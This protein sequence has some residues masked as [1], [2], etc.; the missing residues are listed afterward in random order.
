MR[1]VVALL[2]AAVVLG[3]AGV[4]SAQVRATGTIEGTVL[5]PEGVALPGAQV[6]VTGDSEVAV[7]P[8]VVYTG[9]AGHFRATLLPPG[10]YTVQVSLEGFATAIQERVDVGVRR[11]TTVTV[12]LTLS[13]VEETVTVT[14]AA[15]VVDV[16]TT[17]RSTEVTD[18]VLNTL[19][20]PRGVGGDLMNLSLDASL[21]SGGSL[22][23]NGASFFG[24]T[25]ASNAFQ[26]DGVTVTD[27]SGGSQFPFY[28]PDWFEVID[29]TT[30]GASADQGKA[31]GSI[32]NV[33]TKSGGN[34]YKGEAN[35][36]FQNNSF[37]GYNGANIEST[38]ADFGP[39]NAAK[40]NHRYDFSFNIGG[41]VIR[42]KLW[43]FAGY[44]LFDENFSDTGVVFD[45]TENS[46]RFFGK[47]TW[48]ANNDNRFIVSTMADTYTLGGRPS[49]TY[50]QSFDATAYEPSMNITPNITW[51]TI[52]GPNSFMEV[53]YSGF[54]GYFDLIPVTE[55]PS[56]YD[57]GTGYLS[58]AYWGYYTFDRAR[59]NVQG[60]ISYFAEDF[61]GDHS[62]RVG[63]EWERNLTD[64]NAEYGPNAAGEHYIYYPYFG[65]PYLA[66]QFDP[67]VNRNTSLIYATT[68]YAQDDW[69][70]ANRLT[71]NLGLRFD[72]WSVGY[73]D[74]TAPVEPS[75]NDVSPRL[76]ANLDVFGDGRTS[77]YF[78]WGR[79]YEEVHGAI[80][81]N[82]DP[83]NSQTVAYYWDNQWVE[84]YR[85]GGGG[86]QAISPDL[87]NQW[88]D[89][90][91]IGVD[92]QV[93]DDLSIGARYIHKHDSDIIGGADTGST[94]VPIQLEAVN[95]AL[96]DMWA[97][98]P[99][100]EFVTLVN[101]PNQQFTASDEL[102]RDYNGFQIKVIKR[103]ADNWTVQS[104]FIVQK[105]E[106]NVTNTGTGVNGS[107]SAWKTP[108]SFV[109][110]PGEL[111]NSR[112]YVFKLNASYLFADPIG[113]LVGARWD[114]SSGNPITEY[115]RFSSDDT[116]GLSSGDRTVAI[117][118]YGSN[119]LETIR[120]LDLRLEK[121]FPLGGPY[122]DIG[123][124]FDVF[125]VLNEDTVISVFNR[126]PFY[127]QPTDIVN[128]RTM[129]LGF[130]WLF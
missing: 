119:R 61:A 15:P 19:P 108:N 70:I 96:I 72:H 57:L 123:V 118:Q 129:R 109:N 5:D 66:Y 127:N 68:L 22:Q 29:Q 76:G 12:T 48:Q 94:F 100:D 116:G 95:G 81:D 79:Y 65:E 13:A 8:Q 130:R 41:P 64:D 113:V 17:Q 43:F 54:Y 121:R 30:S 120:N 16:R 84:W 55:A 99:R 23:S 38:Q 7:A 125:N 103:Y 63:A 62:I 114:M 97:A 102:Y 69:T 74:A 60:N 34:D 3:T 47:M 31:T 80:F 128:P 106:G 10:N 71:L 21:P 52:L 44:Q 91:T 42:D 20:E 33:V 112:R 126:V 78:S 1:K 14:G 75:F 122:G 105:A 39:E 53:K 27:P 4:A 58:D 24:G 2:I 82:F 28:S 87:S 111:P 86:D 51:N 117:I 25:T 85:F 18:Q 59:T 77:A 45:A 11:T 35:F 37:I 115:E 98:D 9:P 101:N 92:Q 36:Y 73:I 50:V 104:S 26:V 49:A 89:Q 93:M 88:S 56:S 46:D 40:I 124:V 110:T 67:Q 83:N 6:T 107:T 32:F 90:L